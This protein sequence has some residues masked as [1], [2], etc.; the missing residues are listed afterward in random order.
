MTPS[1]WRSS[2]EQEGRYKRTLVRSRVMFLMAVADLAQHSSC[3]KGRS[4][5]WFSLEQ[6]FTSLLGINEAMHRF[7]GEGEAFDCK[8]IFQ[9]GFQAAQ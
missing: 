1:A 3:S 7:I 8:A 4:V 9:Q 6:D 2:E 5:D